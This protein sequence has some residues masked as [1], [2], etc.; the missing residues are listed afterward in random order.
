MRVLHLSCV[1]AA[2]L[3]LGGCGQN[4]EAA[5]P[6]PEPEAGAAQPAVVTPPPPTAPAEPAAAAEIPGLPTALN[7]LGCFACHGMNEVR[8]GPPYRAI[9]ARYRED[10]QAPERLTV[11]V[12]SGGGGAWGPVPM[13]S[14]P[15]LTPEQVRPLIDAILA[16]K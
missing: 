3:S 16:I 9:A 6:A 7:D 2:A 4:E 11:K 5:P 1:L 10:T 15:R 12:I 13:V 8:I 14:H